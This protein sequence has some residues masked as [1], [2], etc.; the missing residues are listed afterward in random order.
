M[1]TR[2]NKIL[3]ADDSESIRS[4]VRDLL[5]SQEG[6]NICGE[7]SDGQ[8]AVEMAEEL[9]PD[10]IILDLVMPR[11]TGLQAIAEI[12]KKQP[13][14]PI[15][16]YTMHQSKEIDLEAKKAG[17]RMA[18]AKSDST[19]ILLHG[20]QELLAQKSAGLTVPAVLTEQPQPPAE[21][22]ISEEQLT[23]SPAHPE[24]TAKKSAEPN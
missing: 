24:V 17:A 7:A 20:I 11:L 2:T 9:K 12:L 4:S 23:D 8:Q 5:T 18:I 19:E 21:T 16:L 10:L 13:E 15:I 22:P 6:W 1:A 14:V 3:I